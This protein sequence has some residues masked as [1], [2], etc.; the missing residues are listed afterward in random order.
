MIFITVINLCCV[1][2]GGKLI[3]RTII[4]VT[5]ISCII[6]NVTFSKEILS[7]SIRWY[8]RLVL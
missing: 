7:I 6:Q 8:L 5:R 2:V 4:A 3:Y 1:L